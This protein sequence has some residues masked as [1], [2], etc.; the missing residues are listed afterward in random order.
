[1]QFIYFLK[2]LYE[3]KSNKRDIQINCKKKNKTN[4]VT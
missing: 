3:T 4:N 2:S 1:M